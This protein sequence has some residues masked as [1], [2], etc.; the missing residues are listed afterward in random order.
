MRE[1]TG[2]CSWF[3][4]AGNVREQCLTATSYAL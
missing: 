1:T 3:T 4:R 2:S